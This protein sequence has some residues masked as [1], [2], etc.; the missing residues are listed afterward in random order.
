MLFQHVSILTCAI[1]GC[2]LVKKYDMMMG[3]TPNVLYFILS[4]GNERVHQIACQSIW[5]ML[6]CFTGY[7]ITWTLESVESVGF[8]QI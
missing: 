7:V 8:D 2:N 6:R 1:Q 4:A 5:W 3:R